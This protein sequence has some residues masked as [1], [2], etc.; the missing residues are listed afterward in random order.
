MEIIIGKQGNQPMQLNEPSISRRHAILTVN[1]QTGIIKLRD[2]NSANGTW[3]LCPDGRFKRLVSEITV[4]PEMTIRLGA[5]TVLKIKDLIKKD[6]PV[7]ISDLRYVYENYND[8]KLRIE[9]E[10]SNIMMLR[11]ASMSLVGILVTVANVLIPKDFIGD[12]TTSNII[13]LV[14]TVIALGLTWII[15]D[16]KNKGIIRRKSDNEAYLKQS[17]CCPKCG[18][19]FGPKLYSNLLAEGR[20]PNNNCKCKFIGK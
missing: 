9:A 14:V 4:S 6:Q 20:C 7:D 15:V 16:K 5:V 2:T 19:H 13:K 11:M 8:N 12:E 17:Y 3:I 10:S 18:F 1:E